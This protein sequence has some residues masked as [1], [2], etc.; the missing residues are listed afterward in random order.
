MYMPQN[1]LIKNENFHAFSSEKIII[2]NHSKLLKIPSIPVQAFEED[3]CAYKFYKKIK[4]KWKIPWGHDAMHGP[5]WYDL[6]SAQQLF[7]EQPKT[8][9]LKKKKAWLRKN[10]PE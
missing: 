1:I 7:L 5:Q 9:W 10:Y 2:K 3:N 4:I 6:W 8:L